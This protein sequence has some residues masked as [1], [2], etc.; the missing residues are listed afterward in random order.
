MLRETTRQQSEKFSA[1]VSLL[2]R[3]TNEPLKLD[4]SH[5]AWQHI[6][7]I[8]RIHKRCT[9]Y[10]LQNIDTNTNKHAAER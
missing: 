4:E 5:V 7:K 6:I 9:E 10:C 1:A 8:P 2:A 3:V